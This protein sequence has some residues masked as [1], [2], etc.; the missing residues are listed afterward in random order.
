VRPLD[1]P[2]G[3]SGL[4][5]QILTQ[6]TIKKTR[7]EVFEREREERA[8]SAR[9]S[10]NNTSEQILL[11]YALLYMLMYKFILLLYVFY[12]IV[13]CSLLFSCT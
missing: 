10:S 9:V 3:T 7:N 6:Y 4:L 1:S 2:R 12:W 5:H 13:V 11:I 8:R